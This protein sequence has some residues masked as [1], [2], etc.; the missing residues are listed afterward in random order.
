MK[1]AHIIMAYK[2]PSQIARL[3][4]RLSH[5]DCDIYIHLDRKIPFE[6]FRFLSELPRVHFIKNRILCNWGGFSFITATIESMREVLTSGPYDM[7]NLLS[8]QDYPIKSVNEIYSYFKE[9]QDKV[10]TIYELE[11]SDVWWQHA[12][13]R[14]EQ[15]HFTDLRFKG[16]YILQGLLNKF[17]PKRTFPLPYVLYGS[18]NSTWW[19]MNRPSVQYIIDSIDT[20]P[21]LKRFMRYTWAADE[22]L[23]PTLLKNSSFSNMLTNDN[24]R[25][26]RWNKGQANPKVLGKADFESLATSDH[27]FARKFD[28]NVDAD[29]LDMIDRNLL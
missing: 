6:P 28:I 17:L 1:L 18:S 10:F 27:L 22:F 3:I 26:I 20:L 4:E 24:K 25:F 14:F 2:E 19:T 9:N 11:D 8:G 13:T 7:L 5:P 12:T 15:Y 29:I 16:R 23:F 21:S